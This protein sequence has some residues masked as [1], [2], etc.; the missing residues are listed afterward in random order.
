MGSSMSKFYGEERLYVY[1]NFV[2]SSLL[3]LLFGATFIRVWVG[4]HYRLVMGI[5][6]LLFFAN[7][8]YLVNCI[9]I[10][11]FLDIP[12]HA[13]NN[14]DSQIEWNCEISIGQSIGDL[15]FSEAQWMLA[16]FFFKIA[17]NMPRVINGEEMQDYKCVKW[18]G[19]FFN[20]IFPLAEG[21]ILLWYYVTDET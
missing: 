18:T 7:V 11:A 12:A 17:R 15:C 13:Y 8:M 20:A 6:S 16:F 19:I 5:V 21:G 14:G 9:G 4:S 1:T 2:A 10:S 3:I